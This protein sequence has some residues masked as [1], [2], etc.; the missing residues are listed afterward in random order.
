MSVQ[1][2]VQQI[3]A[4]NMIHESV[5]QPAVGSIHNELQPLADIQ[6]TEG[7]PVLDA[8]NGLFAYIDGQT[9]KAQSAAADTIPRADE[10]HLGYRNAADGSALPLREQ[11]GGA[12]WQSAR[13]V[14]G[15]ETLTSQTAALTNTVERIRKEVIGLITERLG[16]IATSAMQVQTTAT[17]SGTQSI[18]T[19]DAAR[20]YVM[21]ITNE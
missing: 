21:G 1:K 10:A 4:A 15:T 16:E 14:K 3:E 11:L 7:N 12:V 8:L 13:T 2:L 19:V 5:I 18:T 17:E 20:V 9:H 6:L